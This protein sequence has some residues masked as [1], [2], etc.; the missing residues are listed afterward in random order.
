MNSKMMKEKFL[1]AMNKLKKK[2]TQ[3]GEKI[4]DE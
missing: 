2:Q 1:N 3:V 4:Q